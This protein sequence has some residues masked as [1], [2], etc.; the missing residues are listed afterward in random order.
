MEM[1]IDKQDDGPA[2]ATILSSVQELLSQSQQVLAAPHA[3]HPFASAPGETMALLNRI[4]EET[5]QVSHALAA[6]LSM[7][8]TNPKV[9]SLYRQHAAMSNA[10]HTVTTLTCLYLFLLH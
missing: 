5:D 7:P 10:L 8:L 3:A 1:S 9:L 2:N 6:S 4:I